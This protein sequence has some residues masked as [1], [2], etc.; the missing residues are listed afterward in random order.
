MKKI[1]YIFMIL[2]LGILTFACGNKAEKSENEKKQTAPMSNTNQNNASVQP[3][4]KQADGD[5]DDVRS[6]NMNV[7]NAG[8]SN[9]EIKNDVDDLRQNNTNKRRVDGNDL[10]KTRTFED[11][12]RNNVKRDFDD[13]GKRDNDGDADDN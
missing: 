11:R 3:V 7:G 5:A 10:N 4:V 12:N 1:I 2:S 13:R 9:V 8:N 6:A